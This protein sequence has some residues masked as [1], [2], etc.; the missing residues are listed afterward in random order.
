MCFS[1]RLISPCTESLY[2]K[3]GE[4]REG[5]YKPDHVSRSRLKNAL[6]RVDVE[7]IHT[8]S[9]TEITGLIKICSRPNDLVSY[10][11]KHSASIPFVKHCFVDVKTVIA[12]RLLCIRFQRRG[13]K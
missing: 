4:G 6:K 9:V 2:R 12:S 3:G 8:R 7:N 11:E 1:R 5:A 13:D 10:R